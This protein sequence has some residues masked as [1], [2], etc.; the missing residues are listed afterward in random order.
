MKGKLQYWEQTAK[1]SWEHFVA[2][3]QIKGDI[4]SFVTQS[5]LRCKA[6]GLNPRLCNKTSVVDRYELESRLQQNAALMAVVL[7]I[8]KELQAFVKDSG[9]MTLFA[10]RDGVI[11]EI[12]SDENLK[13]AGKERNLVIGGVWRE[14]EAGTAGIGLAIVLAQP[15]QIVGA[16]HYHQADHEM[17]CSSAPIFDPGGQLL[18]ILNMSGLTRLTHSH[19]LG[20][21]AAA[22]KAISNQLRI[23]EDHR[24]IWLSNQYLKTVIESIADGVV[25]IDAGGHILEINSE[26]AKI[27]AISTAGARGKTIQELLDGQP[28]LAKVATRGKTVTDREIFIDTRRGRIHCH[29]TAQPIVLEDDK[30]AGA[31]ATLKG[32]KKLH[33]VV[34]QISGAE[35]RFVFSDIVGQSPV[36]LRTIHLAQVAAR[37]MSTVLIQGESGT[38][39]ELFAQAIHTASSPGQPFVAI[40]CAAIPETLIESELFGYEGGAFTGASRNGR[41]GKFELANGGTIFLDE[42]GEMPLNIQAV[43]LRVLQERCIQRIGGVRS[44]PVNVRILAAT[45]KNLALEARQGNFRQDLYYRLNIFKIDV[46]PLRAR[47]DDIALLVDHFVS[48]MAVRYNKSVRGVSQPVLKKLQEYSW[49]GNIRQLENVLERALN[50]ADGPLIEEQHLPDFLQEEIDHSPSRPDTRPTTMNLDSCEQRLIN[51][52]LR[53]TGERQKA[54]ELLGISRSTLYRRLK[55]YGMEDAFK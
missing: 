38:G 47:I 51:D 5:W 50:F 27:L 10:D 15:V 11:L 22:A 14:K 7:P 33:K 21:V 26:A 1:A 28:L 13:E 35:A 4:R 43:L 42:I 44:I 12:M 45:N 30:V 36:M 29:I 9:F 49:P 46:P 40:N 39:K 53:Q 34:N 41:P 18:G 2:T 20:M 31:V 6:H 16:E 52:A 55:K 32:I 25:A 48:C 23:A 8:M 24:Q 37:S 17:T 3:G 54:A 19:T